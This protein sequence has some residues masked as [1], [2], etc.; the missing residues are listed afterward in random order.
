VEFDD[1][2]RRLGISPPRRFHTRFALV[3]VTA[4]L[5]AAVAAG[6]A[7]AHTGSNP[8]GSGIVIIDTNL[9]YQ[10]GQAAGT[11]MVLSSSG[12]VLTNNHVVK[13]AT[14]IRVVEPTTGRSYRATVV[15]YD[16]SDDVAVLQLSGAS[17]LRTIPMADSSNLSTGQAVK[18]IGNAGGT[19]RLTEASGTLTDVNQAISV[20][21]DQGGSENLSGL[22][23]TNA[24]IRPGDSGG[25]LLNSSGQVI[26]MDTAASV[27]QG[28]DQQS[29][30]TGYAIPINKAAAIA[31]QIERGQA[32]NSIHIGGTAFLGV[33][34]S[35][36]EYGN[37]GAVVTAVV[38]NSPAAAAG[39]NPGDLIVSFGG[40]SISS[41]TGLTTIV[42]SQKPGVAT[43]ATYV[44][45]SGASQTADVTLAGGPPR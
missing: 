1:T 31:L 16:V 13:G 44:D 4:A 22:I 39:L 2:E 11:G 7:F 5:G 18:A 8:V 21:D 9:A 41:P 24:G 23:Q 38:P 36:D 30:S 3:A 10:G 35:A 34:V 6:L 20:S 45:Q 42:S 29:S 28:Y 43:S 19:G 32:S 27:S 40:H 25:P 12:T 17:N 15:G 26:G 33:E 37:S 14:A